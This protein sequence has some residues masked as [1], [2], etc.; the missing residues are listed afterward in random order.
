MVILWEGRRGTNVDAPE[1]FD[2]IE[3]DDFF[4]EVVPVVVTLYICEAEVSVDLAIQRSSSAIPL[5]VI[6]K[7]A[8]PLGGFVNHRVHLFMSGCLTLKLSGSWNTVICSLGS[9]VLG[10]VVIPSSL[11]SSEGEMGMVSR[12]TWV[13][14]WACVAVAAAMAWSYSWGLYGVG[15]RRQSLETKKMQ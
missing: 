4:Q 15:G 14:G 3:G 13:S 6:I 7:L 8:L 9:S 1:F 10:A 12:G 11:S 2:G 5:N